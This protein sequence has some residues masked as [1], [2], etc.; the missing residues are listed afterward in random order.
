MGSFKLGR[1]LGFPIEIRHSFLILLGIVFLSGLLN[2][3]PLLS[4]ALLLI[5]FLS[6]LA[7]EL[8]HAL[9]ARRLGVH[10]A[11]IDLHIFGGAAKMVGMP[12]GPKDEI[13]IAAAGPVVS[14]TLA[15]AGALLH[16]ISGFWG[17]YYLMWTNLL[18]GVFN[19]LPA[20][21]MDGGRIFRAALTPKMGFQ[22]A[23]MLSVKVA[24]GIAVALGL[25]G[26][27]FNFWLV[28][29]AVMLWMMAGQELMIA[30]VMGYGGGLGAS[31]FPFGGSSPPPRR[32][33]GAADSWQRAKA[34]WRQRTSRHTSR[35]SQEAPPAELIDRDGRNLG[36]VHGERVMHG[37][38]AFTIET[39]RQHGVELWV[40]RDSSGCILMRSEHPLY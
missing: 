26:L 37:G 16:A 38:S 19:L 20:L 15:L 8:G 36:Q 34:F 1:V 17:F 39:I 13:A 12:R 21:P 24:R 10:I 2:G 32:G 5:T 35:P 7:H 14:L 31:F 40:V 30:Q 11:G 29:L 33:P 23:T 22:G 6:V 9:V 3:H 27:F 18:L 25:F 4:V 28:A